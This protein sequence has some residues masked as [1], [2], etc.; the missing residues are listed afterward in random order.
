MLSLALER[1][2]GDS[3]RQEPSFSI[4]ASLPETS[5]DFNM[6]SEP[7]AK[8]SAE[9]ALANQE[10]K[11]SP[12]KRIPFSEISSTQNTL[13][14][15]RK[16]WEEMKKAEGSPYAPEN[17]KIRTDTDE[18]NTAYPFGGWINEDNYHK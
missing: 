12:A 10:E 17:R 16:E 3:S 7:E 18:D 2:F 9:I 1:S 6:I 8:P 5:T 14:N 15:L 4:N 11:K 13:N